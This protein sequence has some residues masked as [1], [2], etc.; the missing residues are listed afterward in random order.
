MTVTTTPTGRHALSDTRPPVTRRAS[1][2]AEPEPDD[3]VDPDEAYP[4]EAYPDEEFG[5]SRRFT[6]GVGLVLLVGGLVGAVAAVT[7]LLE[8]LALLTDP[9]YIP[10]CSIDPVLSCGTIMRTAQAGV[11]GF[12]NPIIG[13]ATF[14]LVAGMGALVVSGVR[15]PRWCWFA[16]QG[17]ATLG[18]A[19]VLWLVVQ[20]VTAI[21]ALCPYCMVVWVVVLAVF[22][23]VTAHNMATGDLG[24]GRLSQTLVRRHGVV[25]A[26]GYVALAAVVVASFPDYWASVVGL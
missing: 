16:L 19:F 24:G 18:L 17:G 25:L 9:G 4:D 13:V 10:S 12:P 15:L 2:P 7:L 14:P 22:W 3:A 1:G 11:F 21:H 20:S 23:Y 26:L 8:K 6:R 5:P